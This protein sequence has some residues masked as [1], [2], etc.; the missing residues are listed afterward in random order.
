MIINKADAEDMCSLFIDMVDS[1][2]GSSV[3]H[4][5]DGDGIEKKNADRI[6]ELLSKYKDSYYK[7]DGDIKIIWIEI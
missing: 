5:G 1:I 4:I 6:R 3:H 2:Y 7:D